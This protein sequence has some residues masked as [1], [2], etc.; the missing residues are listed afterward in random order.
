M[1]S[2]PKAGLISRVLLC[3][4]SYTAATSL[5]QEFRL[6]SAGVRGGTGATHSVQYFCETDAFADWNLPWRWSLGANWHL[7]PRLDI[8]AGWL[9][10]RGDNAFVG[11]LGPSIVVLP[12]S[13]PLSIEGGVS[14]AGISRFTYEGRDLG[15]T[16]QFITHAGVNWDFA[17]RWRIGYRFQHM[18]NGD[19]SS[20]NPGLNMN[21]LVLSYVF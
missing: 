6:E 15:S 13:L 21:M 18:S 12:P 7:Q 20:P 4:L 16:L 10:E 5:A 2:S 17:R 8:S 9:G 14:P 3:M 11:S 19:L 1:F